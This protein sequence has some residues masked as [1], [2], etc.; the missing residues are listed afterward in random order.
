MGNKGHGILYSGSEGIVITRNAISHNYKN[1][2]FLTRPAELTI[3]DNTID[4]NKASGI[5]IDIGVC[6]TVQGNGIYHNDEYGITTSGVG[7][8]KEND[9]F[10]HHLPAVQVKAPSDPH[11]QNN[12]I[13]AVQHECLYAE[14]GTR[15][16]IE[17]NE[18]YH[19]SYVKP[20][21]RHEN[22]QMHVFGNKFFVL[23]KRDVDSIDAVDAK[24]DMEYMNLTSPPP[25]PQITKDDSKM[26]PFFTTPVHKK[27]GNDRHR[28]GVMSQI[29][30]IL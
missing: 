13:Q 3:Q 7:I 25:R 19:Y 30:A 1:G 27:S 12:R 18:I 23:I 17:R 6:C 16:L 2:V 8:I 11:I 14:D 28:G 10:G 22:S 24:L 15:G 26:A 4:H 29:C 9:I 20:I 21:H 5:V